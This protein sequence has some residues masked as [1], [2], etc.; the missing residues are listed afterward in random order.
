MLKKFSQF[1]LLFFTAF[2]LLA[3]PGMAATADIANKDPK[4]GGKVEISGK[5]ASGKDLYVVI[6]S[7]KMFKPGDSI[8]SKEKAKLSKLFGDTAIP[9]VYYVI[10]NSPGN[11]AIPKVV[12][13]GRWFPPFKWDMEVNKIKKWGKIPEDVRL[14]LGPISTEKQ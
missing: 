12:S 3:G 9:P 7:E 6:C 2:L 8:G 5:I 11:L 14:K 13:K 4:A 10:S 1:F